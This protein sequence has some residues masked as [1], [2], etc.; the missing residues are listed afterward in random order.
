[1]E[2][3]KWPKRLS[4]PRWQNIAI[5]RRASCVA[6][7]AGATRP[8]N[9]LITVLLLNSKVNEKLTPFN[10]I[11]YFVAIA[12]GNDTLGLTME[13]LASARGDVFRTRAAIGIDPD[14][15]A[16]EGGVAR[17]DDAVTIA[18]ERG[19][20]GKAVAARGADEFVDADRRVGIG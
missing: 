7:Y 11:Y 8:P 12:H 2:T 14:T 18:V 13:E 17:V 15:Q 19:E 1:M 20:I 5:A 4:Q 3:L 6:H 16:R 10:G 9:A